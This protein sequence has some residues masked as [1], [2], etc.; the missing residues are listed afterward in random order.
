ME[1]FPPHMMLVKTQDGSPSI[2]IRYDH[3][4]ELMH[5]SHGAFTE[6]IYIYAH[7]LAHVPPES[8]PVRILSI[9]LGLAYNEIISYSWGTAQNRKVE[10]LSFEVEPFLRNQFTDWVLNRRENSLSAS[11]QHILDRSAKH[12]STE[13][14]DVFD[15]L[16]AGL[17]KQDLSIQA[18]FELD[19]LPQTPFDVV[20]FDPFSKKA[21]PQ[22]WTPEFLGEFIQRACASSC[23]FS[24]YAATGD[25][26]RAL[27]EARFDVDL[28]DGFSGKKHSI[29][30]TRHLPKV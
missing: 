4:S 14:T 2:E 3:T 29:F 17:A 15:S 24:T 26:K 25:L 16:Q 11:Y 23:I 5:H 30:A 18:Q 6:S 27:K 9:G 19:L 7:A 22:F 21:S 20:Y 8:Q 28:R 10:I 12:F 1:I 13:P